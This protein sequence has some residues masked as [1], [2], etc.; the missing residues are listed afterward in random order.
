MAPADM[1]TNLPAHVFLYDGRPGRPRVAWVGGNKVMPINAVV[2]LP[3]SNVTVVE[4]ILA[5]VTTEPKDLAEIERYSLGSTL[6]A[7]EVEPVAV[8]DAQATKNS[9]A[10]SSGNS[11]KE[12][13][14]EIRSSSR[15]GPI[16][17][18]K[19]CV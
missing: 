9:L 16:W 13:S 2:K 15:I 7:G 18:K 4:P 1:V 8:A 17:T 14:V 6:D 3:Q 12:K 10:D 11:N 19:T 5:E